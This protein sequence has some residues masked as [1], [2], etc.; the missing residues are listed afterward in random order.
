MIKESAF[1][2]DLWG[3]VQRKSY[4]NVWDEHVCET[5]VLSVRIDFKKCSDMARLW[6]KRITLE[7]VYSGLL[8][9]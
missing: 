2:F 8:K 3:M 4:N 7:E 9:M 1:L 6:L 5:D